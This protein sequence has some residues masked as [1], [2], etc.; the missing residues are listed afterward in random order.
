ML[1]PNLTETPIKQSEIRTKLRLIN[2]L[3]IASA[4]IGIFGAWEIVKGATLEN[5]NFKHIELSHKL[6]ATADDFKAGRLND[7]Q[8]LTQIVKNIREQPIACLKIIGPLE[9]VAMRFAGT[10]K[11]SDV[12][13][14]D[15]LL[16]DHTLAMIN[17][18]EN[19]AVPKS[20]LIMQLERSIIEFHKNSNEFQPLVKSTV[21]FVFKAMLAI[22]VVKGAIISYIGMLLSSSISKNYQFLERAQKRSVRLN[23]E[24][25]LIF[26]SAPVFLWLL[27]QDARIVRGNTFAAKKTGQNVEGLVGRTF[28]EFLPNFTDRELQN[29]KETITAGASLKGVI[30]DCAPSNRQNLWV[31]YQSAPYKDRQGDYYTLL[32]GVD[33]TQT[34]KQRKALE[35]SEERYNLAVAGASEGIWDYDLCA[36][37]LHYSKRNFEL[38]GETPC[39]LENSLEWW[40]ARVHPDDFQ[41]VRKAAIAHLKS[42]APYDI[43]YR[44][45]HKNGSWRWWRTRGKAIRDENSKPYRMVGT[46]SDVTDLIKAKKKAETANEA[47]SR[48]L[49]N[50][51]H[52]IRTPMNGILGMA[53]ILAHS[54]LNERQQQMLDTINTSGE[55]L[56]TVLDDV[57]DLSKIEVDQLEI[58][59]APFFIQD[60]I[61]SVKDL[62]TENAV[63]K[64]LTLS[65]TISD[66]L[67]AQM[68]GDEVRLRQILNNLVSNA[69]K[70]TNYGEIALAACLDDNDDDNLKVKFTVSDTGIGMAQREMERMFE[71]FVQADLTATRVHSGTGLGLTISQRLAQLMGGSLSVVTAPN[72]GSTFSV[73]IPLEAVN[74]TNINNTEETVITDAPAICPPKNLKILAAE[75]NEINRLVL[76][77]LLSHYECDLT[78]VEDGNQAINTWKDGAF[79]LVMMDIQMPLIDGVTAMKEIR[80]LEKE[81]NRTRTYMVALTANA[82]T[83]QVEDYLAAGADGHIAKPIIE[84][85]LAQTLTQAAA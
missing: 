61:S 1:A 7:T 73:V 31:R 83:Y 39:S 36:H 44:I 54:Q 69:I 35:Q 13:R 50:M 51:S 24:L 20:H 40:E 16:A 66:A 33:I 53:Q 47:K 79:D 12:C 64:G 55:A 41:M 82:M 17:D 48:F 27:D 80:R 6:V 10:A 45:L 76:K 67:S 22:I 4:I 72:K 42:K 11:A 25:K 46:N 84:K 23:N 9:Q 34:L 77:Q 32:V 8:P 68:I 52:E 37:Q 5:L 29:L 56:L 74:E 30:F 65:A 85:D 78:I 21:Q 62:Y 71:P 26:N 28:T 38:L 60:L 14:R 70:F 58:K 2:V 19:G 15:I 18:Y 81:L 3:F 75:D 43:T 63:A 59:P 57:L 49:A